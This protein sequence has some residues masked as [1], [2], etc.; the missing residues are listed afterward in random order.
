VFESEVRRA[1]VALEAGR[2]A[3]AAAS[4]EHALSLWT[5][6]CLVDVAKGPHLEARVFQLEEVRMRARELAVEAG[7]ALGRERALVPELWSL[8]AQYPLHEWFHERLIVALATCGRRGEALRAYH[9]LRHLLDRELGLAPSVQI[10]QL[11]TNILREQPILS[12]I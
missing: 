4:L 11:H 6:P 8:I 7:F 5:G 1:H 3:E 2:A 12:G 10:E 9:R